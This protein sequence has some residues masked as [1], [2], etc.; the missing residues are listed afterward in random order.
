M[1]LAEALAIRTD[2]QKKIAQMDSRL[3]A[4]CK[5]QE[6]DTPAENPEE[7]FK[8]FDDYLDSLEKLVCQINKTN[9]NT[10][11]PDG[12][13]LSE[14]IALRD[15]LKVK[16]QQLQALLEHLLG[17]GERYSRQEIKYVISVNQKDVRR[18][19]DECSK[20]LRL[21]DC[22]IQAMNWT[23]DLME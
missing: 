16:V 5:V 4:A 10:I 7:L 23:V 14:K 21:V 22:D 15:K 11:M 3:K 19:M 2:L 12:M 18:R 20:H 17:Q 8:N 6:G 9:Q 1:K 13:T